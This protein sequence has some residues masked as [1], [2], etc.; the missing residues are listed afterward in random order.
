MSYAPNISEENIR[1]RTVPAFFFE[2]KALAVRILTNYIGDGVKEEMD[3]S[4][5]PK[6]GKKLKTAKN[7][8]EE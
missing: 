7:E 1:Q 4:S 6:T 8:G 3:R 5:T 2:D